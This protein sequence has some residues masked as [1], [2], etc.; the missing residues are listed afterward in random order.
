M[1]LGVHLHGV[2]PNEAQPTMFIA[3][4][5]YLHGDEAASHRVLSLVGSPDGVAMYDVLR[6]SGELAPRIA[7]AEEVVFIDVE[8]RLGDPWMEPLDRRN[9]VRRG[10]IPAERNCHVVNPPTVQRI[11]RHSSRVPVGA[12]PLRATRHPP[13][14]MVQ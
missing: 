11:T 13:S 8:E 6:L 4:G 9:R 5:S 1:A 14:L 2:M 7:S 3:A 12:E 10:A